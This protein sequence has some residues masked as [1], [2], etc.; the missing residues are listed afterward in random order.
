M[1]RSVISEQ[2]DKEIARMFKGGTSAKIIGQTLGLTSDGVFQ[3]IKRM[4]ESG[5][6]LPNPFQRKL[7]LDGAEIDP[8]RASIL[9]LL[10]LKRA[11][12]SPTQTEFSITSERPLAARSYVHQGSLVGSS[13]AMCCD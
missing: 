7:G 4:R 13:A 8:R 11:G 6:D 1:V 5:M 2:T 3:R 9:H 10:D 12:H